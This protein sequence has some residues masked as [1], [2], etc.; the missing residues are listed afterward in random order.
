VRDRCFNLL[1][2]IAASGIQSG[3]R[4]IR[5]AGALD[6]AGRPVAVLN[7]GAV[8]HAFKHAAECVCHDVVLAPLIFLPASYPRGLP[9][10][11]VFTDWL[12]ML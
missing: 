1:P 6:Q 12:S 3:E 2:G 11:V 8:H 10:S 5:V 4:G 9:A 7:I